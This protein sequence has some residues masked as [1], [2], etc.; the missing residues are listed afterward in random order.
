MTDEV[1]SRL[2]AI[3]KEHGCGFDSQTG[4]TMR[5]AAKWSKRVTSGQQELAGGLVVPAKYET[6]PSHEPLFELLKE[7]FK[8]A[9]FSWS[10]VDHERNKGTDNSRVV[11]VL[12]IHNYPG[13]KK[14]YMLTLADLF[15][16]PAEQIDEYAE[17]LRA[18]HR[19][20]LRKTKQRRGAGRFSGGLGCNAW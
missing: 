4:S 3:R 17:A 13:A 16:L 11:K 18:V 14:G 5:H 2:D 10:V 8:G 7:K 20:T 15:I 6:F 19:R 9:G 1:V 12:Q